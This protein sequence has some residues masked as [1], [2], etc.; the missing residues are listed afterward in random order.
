[1]ENQ[2]AEEAPEKL[3][4][5]QKDSL[6]RPALAKTLATGE[7]EKI[8]QSQKDRLTVTGRMRIAHLHAMRRGIARKPAPQLAHR[9]IWSSSSAKDPAVRRKHTHKRTN[10]FILFP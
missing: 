5:L 1:M 3:L 10:R 6:I 9:R 7:K 8:T 4:N 2:D